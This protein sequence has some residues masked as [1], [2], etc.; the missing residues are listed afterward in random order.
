MDDD[1]FWG[2]L[3]TSESKVRFT[4]IDRT[5][6]SRDLPPTKL[7]HASPSLSRRGR[8]IRFEITDLTDAHLSDLKI[9]QA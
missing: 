2:M 4:K 3:K 8:E 7:N 1:A 5:S 6:P 9:Y